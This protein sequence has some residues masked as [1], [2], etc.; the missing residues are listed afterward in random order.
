MKVPT[1]KRVQRYA[2]VI[3][4]W[5][6]IGTVVFFLTMATGYYITNNVLPK[7]YT[8]SSVVQLPASDLA[9]PAGSGLASMALQPE[10][11]NTMHV[12]G[13]AAV[14]GER[15]RARQGMGPKRLYNKDGR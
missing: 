5:L 10:F 11:L 4:R 6:V 13:A 12:A 15:P 1:V 9:T 7:V 14:R 2:S 8:A 3:V